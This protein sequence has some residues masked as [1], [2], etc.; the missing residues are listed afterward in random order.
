MAN[1]GKI[2][3][4]LDAVTT[5]FNKKMKGATRTVRKFTSDMGQLAKKAIKFG[6]VMATAAV[7]GLTAFVKKS[8]DSIDT[9]AKT[10]QKLGIAT[11]DLARLRVAAQLSGVAANTLD[12]ALQRMTR[13]VAEAAIGTGEAKDAIKQLGLDAGTLAQM[14]PD[15][16]FMAIADAMSNVTSQGERVR[17]AFKLF[18]SEGVALV[19]TLMLGEQG[20]N[21][22]AAAADRMGVSLT[23]VEAS[24]V[25]AA[26]D[27]LTKIGLV[28]QGIG[29]Q[30]AVELAPAIEWAATAFEQWATSGGGA[31]EKVKSALDAVVDGI[32]TGIDAIDWMLDKWDSVRLA[33]LTVEA[34]AVKVGKGIAD[35]ISK[36]I[37][38]MIAGVL[39]TI[40]KA[41]EM[42]NKIPGVNISTIGIKGL[43]GAN[44]MNESNLQSTRDQTL[45]DRMDLIQGRRDEIEQGATARHAGGSRSARFKLGARRVLSGAGPAQRMRATGPTLPDRALTMNGQA[46]DRLGRRPEINGQLAIPRMGRTMSVN[47]TNNIGKRGSSKTLNGETAAELEVLNQILEAIRR[48]R[49]VGVA[50]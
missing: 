44:A 32:G 39:A 36:G 48:E 35:A 15:Q 45:S 4:Q 29:T 2:S 49:V 11:D 12:M 7:V 27:A 31:G 46:S 18:D 34:T 16:Q 5:K 42:A 17:L 47:G 40:Q 23:N 8:I 41:I 43:M 14:S 13:R 22:A 9:L 28:F 30:L 19:N 21:E 20:L 38:G 10:S 26:K 37:S 25:V 24:K 50:G 33:M 6:A 1:I 3:V